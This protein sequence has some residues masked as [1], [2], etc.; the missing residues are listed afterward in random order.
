MLSKRKDGKKETL[1]GLKED[2]AKTEKSINSGKL[3]EENL[4]KAK[5]YRHMLQCD[6]EE[7]TEKLAKFYARRA[8]RVATKKA[9][10]AKTA[11]PKA[12]KKAADKPAVRDIRKSK[13][14]ADK[15]MVKKIDAAT[16]DQKAATKKLADAKAAKKA[17]KKVS[18]ICKD[19]R[20]ITPFGFVDEL[21]KS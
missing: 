14:Q 10:A 1:H 5:N 2:L 7:Y 18:Q 6:L 3:S 4:F 20:P 12:A 9:E 13:D 19:G 8:E 11:S 16:A 17:G 15:A 21:K